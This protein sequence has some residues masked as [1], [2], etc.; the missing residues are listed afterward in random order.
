MTGWR[1]GWLAAPPAVV[2]AA[3]RTLSATITHVPQV[4]Q[5][6]ALEALSKGSREQQATKAAYRGRRDRAHHALS[7]LPGVTCPRPDGGGSTKED[8]VDFVHHPA[9]AGRPFLAYDAPGCGETT[10]SDVSKLS[11]PFLLATARAVLDALDVERLHLVGHSM[12]GLTAP[13]LAANGVELAGIAQSGHWPIYSNAVA[14]WERIDRFYEH[15][16]QR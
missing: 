2:D 3:T 15:H 10:C 7:A 13:T 9:F 4:P 8:Y 12:G 16:A 5:V 14:A 1:V 11:I 6:A